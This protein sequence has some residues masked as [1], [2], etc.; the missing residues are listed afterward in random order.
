MTRVAGAV[1]ALLASVAT[2]LADESA[3]LKQGTRVRVHYRE[4]PSAAVVAV[5][6]TL[7]SAD[8]ATVT[9]IST[10][11]AGV[12]FPVESIMRIE[13]SRGRHR[14]LWS[15]AIAGAAFG[16]VGSGVCL[17]AGCG[18]NGGTVARATAV[19]GGIGGL[20]GVLVQGEGW[21]EVPGREVRVG[22]TPLLGR[23]SAGLAAVVS[24]Q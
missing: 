19:W 8:R 10:Q 2:A 18:G 12:T 5:T 22:V 11:A 14:H 15:G 1:V 20:L 9:L 4:S 13:V 16:L 23:G 3:G 7:V 21:Q 17:A 6:G 24:W